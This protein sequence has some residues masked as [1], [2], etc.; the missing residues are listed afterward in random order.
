[1]KNGP[2]TLEK[3]VNMMAKIKDWSDELEN[4][5]KPALLIVGDQDAPSLSH[6]REMNRK[7]QGSEFHVISDCGHVCVSEKPEEISRLML[8]F[9]CRHSRGLYS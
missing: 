5:D 1:M 8:D 6:M 4:I 3:F 9:L 7:I 2:D